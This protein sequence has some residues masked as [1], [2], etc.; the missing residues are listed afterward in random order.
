MSTFKGEQL[1]KD[2]DIVTLFV[3]CTLSGD[4]LYFCKVS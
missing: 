1:K 3:V 2:I 4:A